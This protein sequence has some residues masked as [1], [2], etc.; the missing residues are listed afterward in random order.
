VLCHLALTGAGGIS[1][2]SNPSS[3]A[4]RKPLAPCSPLVAAEDLVLAVLASRMC[5]SN[6]RATQ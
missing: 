1:P 2:L 4:F 5:T 3:L 6:R